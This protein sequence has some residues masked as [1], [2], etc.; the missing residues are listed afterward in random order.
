VAKKLFILG[1]EY[2][3]SRAISVNNGGY[4]A[5]CDT[6][7]FEI[8]LQLEPQS[9]QLEDSA[10]I[11]EVIEAGNGHLQLE[12]SHNQIMGIE[13]TVYSFLA[14]NGVDLSPLLDGLDG[15]KK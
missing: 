14:R 15:G 7:K 11:H 1:Y 12:L 5:V 8:T 3:L 10:L 13:A 4:V 2:T 6:D 9:R